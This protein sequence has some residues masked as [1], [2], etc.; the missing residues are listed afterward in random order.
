MPT[1]DTLFDDMPN[2]NENTTY[3]SNNGMFIINLCLCEII[4]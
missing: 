4:R 2:E 1:V 3:I